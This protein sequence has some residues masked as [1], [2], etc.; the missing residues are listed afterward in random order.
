MCKQKYLIRLSLNI[1]VILT[2][3]VEDSQHIETERTSYGL[4]RSLEH[5]KH[6]RACSHLFEFCD[7]GQCRYSL[8]RVTY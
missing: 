3:P 2:V 8:S 6:H 1:K 5:G 7:K 4:V